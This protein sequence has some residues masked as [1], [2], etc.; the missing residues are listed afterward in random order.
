MF[1]GVSTVFLILNNFQFA[2]FIVQFQNKKEI[3]NIIDF[4]LEN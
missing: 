4:L 2:M 1:F 3:V